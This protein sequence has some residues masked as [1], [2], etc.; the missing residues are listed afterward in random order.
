VGHA[1]GYIQVGRREPTKA[2]ATR[3]RA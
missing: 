1:S 2:P 3:W